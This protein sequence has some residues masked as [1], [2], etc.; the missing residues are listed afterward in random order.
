MLAHVI[1]K[2][3]DRVAFILG[4]D[5]G[6]TYFLASEKISENIAQ[7]LPKVLLPLKTL[8][9]KIEFLRKHYPRLYKKAIRSV[10]SKDIRI[11]KQYEL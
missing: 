10:K 7:R 9:S 3:K 1:F 2:E 4:T 6:K 5:N 11:V 8:G